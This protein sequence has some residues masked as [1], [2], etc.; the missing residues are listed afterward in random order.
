MDDHT[1]ELTNEELKLV[2]SALHSYLDDF[3]HEE[4]DVLRAIKQLLEKLPYHER[5]FE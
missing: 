5:F 1:I 4:A 3:G 2:R